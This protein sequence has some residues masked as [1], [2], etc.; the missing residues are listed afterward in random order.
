M[1]IKGVFFDF[2]GTLYVLGDMTAE[3]N[4]WI[5]EFYI[6]LGS[7]SISVKVYLLAFKIGS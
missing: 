5:P 7:T 3:L 2:Y 1:T 4:E 6:R